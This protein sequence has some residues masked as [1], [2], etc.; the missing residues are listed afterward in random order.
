MGRGGEE[1]K[2]G[3]LMKG[4]LMSGLPPWAAWA[5]SH[6]GPSGKPWHVILWH[7]WPIPCWE[8]STFLGLKLSLGRE[9]QGNS[10]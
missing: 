6:W 1:G 2:K 7:L 3:K 4:V 8:Q 5:L 9:T 10:L